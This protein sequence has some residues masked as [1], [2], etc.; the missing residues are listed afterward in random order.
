[1]SAACLYLGKTFVH[2]DKPHHQWLILGSIIR[3]EQ[4]SLLIVDKNNSTDSA[5]MPFGLFIDALEAGLF[6]ELK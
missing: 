4:R 5:F 3:N 1:M 6:S 2:R